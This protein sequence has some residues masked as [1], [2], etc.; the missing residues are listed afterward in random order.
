MPAHRR[1]VLEA[2]IRQE[3][4]KECSKHSATQSVVQEEAL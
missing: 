3:R 2:H 4:R 1:N